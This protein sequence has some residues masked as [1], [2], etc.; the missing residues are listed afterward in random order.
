M[1]S[2][3]SLQ[4]KTVL[5]P[6]A[7]N[8]A[9]GFS[10]TVRKYGGVPVEIPL[11][12]FRPVVP[13]QAEMAVINNIQAYDWI[14]FTSNS[15]VATFFSLYQGERQNLPRVAAIGTKTAQELEEKGV[16]VE[17]VPQKY[18]AEAFVKEFAPLVEKGAKIFLPK[19]NLARDYIA[20][21]LK[22]QGIIVDEMIIYD[23]FFPEESKA[24][25]A[26]K[27]EEEELDII[28]FTSP[29]T[30]DHF[31]EIVHEYG[32]HGKIQSCLF[33]CIGPVARKRAEELGLTI[34][35]VPDVYTVE[36]M[37]KK[38]AQYLSQKQDKC[39][40]NDNGITI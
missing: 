24:L 18:V 6:R 28:P 7:K 27:L 16:R 8:S 9:R 1:T 11:L 32:L 5:N 30:A 33:A 10:N 3:C 38:I 35:V 20:E 37:I 34:D 2:S 23:T 31:M 26:Q 12:A 36:E 29:S 25:L 21:T 4:N 15:T 40:G 19:G 17:F 39:R 13:S 14:I 22:Q